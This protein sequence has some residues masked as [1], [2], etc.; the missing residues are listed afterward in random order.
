MKI[1]VLTSNWNGLAGG[2]HEIEKPSRELY[3]LVG[4]AEAAGVVKVRAIPME[5]REKLKKHVE[6]QAA[7]EKAYERAQESGAWLEGQA[8]QADLDAKNPDAPKVSV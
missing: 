6:S 8:I 7:S 3:G 4:G 5:D 2:V 1:E